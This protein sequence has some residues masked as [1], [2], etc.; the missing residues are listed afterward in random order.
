FRCDGAADG[1]QA[2][3]LADRT[4]YDAVVTDLRMPNKHGH[5][6]VVELLTRSHRPLIVVL[7]GIVE[8]RL[9]KDLVA[10][11]VDDIMF[12]PVE[13]ELL[14]AKVKA[15]V[16]QKGTPTAEDTGDEDKSP[17]DATEQS[18]EEKAES[19]D[20]PARETDVDR[21]PAGIEAADFKRA[22]A[23][24]HHMMPASDDALHIYRM[25]KSNEFDTKQLA[26]AI[27]KHRVLSAEVLQLANSRFYNPKGTNITNLER[28]VLQIGQT[29]I[30]QLALAANSQAALSSGESPWPSAGPL[31]R[32]SV[33]AGL[34]VELLVAQG[35]HKDISEGLLLCAAMHSLGRVV[36]ASL[37][38]DHYERMI[39]RCCKDR[40]AL[41]EL[42]RRAF[43][44]SQAEVMSDVLQ[45]WN[46]PENLYSPL[47]HVEHDYALVSQLLEPLRSQVELVKL[48]ALISHIA[49][50]WWDP[51]DRVVIPTADVLDRLRLLSISTAIEE[52]KRNAQGIND[53]ALQSTDDSDA[54][55]HTR[56]TGPP[57][58]IAYWK[59]GVTEFDFLAEIVT[60]MNITLIPCPDPV[61]SDEDVL[62]N[63]LGSPGK[64]VLSLV[65]A[66]PQS[67]ITIVC[68]AEN[69]ANFAAFDRVVSIPTS[70]SALQNAVMG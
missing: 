30:G 64:E 50:G 70:Y 40:C 16:G 25:T 3:A 27:E 56:S 45:S 15:L 44:Q 33:A 38:P 48:A 62:V 66:C 32:R 65:N 37:Y 18:Y 8:P 47:P 20:D 63:G 19:D 51:W 28:G 6:L 24:I 61:D 36:L 7:T 1:N 31:W 11:G 17:S 23:R 42:E 54:T 35:G 2:L 55:P 52:T 68:D 58:S 46:I 9:A 13:Y 59:P 22:F 10:R 60:S 14:A 21:G 4:H 41:V 57:Q 39:N 34:A 12:K 29:R 67:R 5:A 69:E 26:L 43:P 53:F 49:T